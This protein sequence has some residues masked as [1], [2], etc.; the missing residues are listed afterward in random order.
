MSRYVDIEPYEKCRI[1]SNSEDIGVKVSD[2]ITIDA[3][4]VR[5]GRW[6]KEI[7]YEE[8]VDIEFLKCTC[9]ICGWVT[10]TDKTIGIKYNYCPYC[11]AK[12]DE[13]DNT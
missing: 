10:R 8:I 9:S 12:M 3:E 6:I 5:H 13:E 4:P 1:V 2:L 11:G 7:D